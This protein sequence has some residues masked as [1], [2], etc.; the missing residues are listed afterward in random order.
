MKEL[1]DEIEKFDIRIQ[2][3]E[4]MFMLSWLFQTFII[5]YYLFISRVSWCSLSRIRSESYQGSAEYN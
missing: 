5:S 1:Q 4:G 3:Y 2:F